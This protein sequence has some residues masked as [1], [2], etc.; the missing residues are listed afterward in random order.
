M[1]ISGI[2]LH[3]LHSAIDAANIE[4]CEIPAIPWS[5]NSTSIPIFRHETPLTAS[6]F[7]STTAQYNPCEEIPCKHGVCQI[8]G[9]SYGYSCMC[10]YGY[11][12]INCEHVL[13]QCEML[14]PCRNGGTC[15]DLHG[16]YN[17]DCPL[18]YSGKDC[19][20]RKYLF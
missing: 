10:E 8:S 15:L 11:V 3:L 1:E 18:G 17:C 6:S 19:E 5:H 13:K 16:A 9:N 4:D 14:R 20:K 7:T 12:G 2:N